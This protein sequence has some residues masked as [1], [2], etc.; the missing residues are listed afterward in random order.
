MGFTAGL[1]LRGLR[2]PCPTSRPASGTRSDA[3]GTD[4][5][6]I[7][8]PAFIPEMWFSFMSPNPQ[9]SH[10]VIAPFQPGTRFSSAIS[11]VERD[12]IVAFAAEFDPQPQHLDE[13]AAA[14]SQ[15]G[16]LVASGWHT[17]AL[18]M[19]LFIGSL[20]AIPGGAMGVGVDE[21]RWL[22]AVRPGDELRTV[23]TVKASRASASQ[24]GKLVVTCQV[25][26]QNQLDQ[27]V[28]RFLTTML[29]A[30]GEDAAVGASQ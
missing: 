12:R 14:A 9:N 19:R 11:R 28:L 10:A 2:S 8:K 6:Q 29:V 24:S 30:T 13:V 15:F 26:M 7:R 3:C 25:V 18:A 17:A 27:D 22:M 1:G 23:T 16:G 5:L 4:S 21:L 20:P